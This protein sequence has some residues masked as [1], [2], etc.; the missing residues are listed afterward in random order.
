[1]NQTIREK[2]TLEVELSPAEINNL[3]YIASGKDDGPFWLRAVASR[4]VAAVDREEKKP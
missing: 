2:H 3:R 1:M 4:I